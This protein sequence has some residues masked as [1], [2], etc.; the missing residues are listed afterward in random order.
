[1]AVATLPAPARAADVRLEL[2]LAT[3]YALICSRVENKGLS[4]TNCT[5]VSKLMG[6]EEALRRR[7]SCM[8]VMDDSKVAQAWDALHG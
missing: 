2:A 4:L 7:S 5:E 8:H 6:A 3:R 1:M